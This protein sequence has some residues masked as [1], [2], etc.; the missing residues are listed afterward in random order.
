[1]D[2]YDRTIRPRAL[3]CLI[4]RRNV[5]IIVTNFQVSNESRPLHER[6]TRYN[7]VNTSGFNFVL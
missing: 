2:Y 4:C 3:K 7:K 6:I 5:T 1:M